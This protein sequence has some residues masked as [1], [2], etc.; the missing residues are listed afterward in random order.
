MSFPH[1]LLGTAVLLMGASASCSPPGK[2]QAAG[3]LL[4]PT[5]NRPNHFAV[6]DGVGLPSGV[7]CPSR[8]P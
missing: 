8:V 6:V 1:E 5:A 3:L 7:G 2:T 4:L